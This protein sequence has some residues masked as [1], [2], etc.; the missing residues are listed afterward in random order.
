MSRIQ[1]LMT[2]IRRT[3]Q[4]IRDIKNPLR[5]R[6]LKL[7]NKVY[8]RPPGPNHDSSMERLQDRYGE[9]A[10]GGNDCSYNTP[11]LPLDQWRSPCANQEDGERSSSP[12]PSPTPTSPCPSHTPTPACEPTPPVASG[13]PGLDGTPCT[14]AL[15]VLK[16]PSSSEEEEMESRS[17]A[18]ESP[19]PDEGV[20]TRQ[21]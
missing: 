20:T 10:L 4:E 3:C 1:T 14:A 6:K 19:D 21:R 5:S 7:I 13:L 9:D 12:P 11:N 2:H 16:L 15:D 17:G 8:S 18:G